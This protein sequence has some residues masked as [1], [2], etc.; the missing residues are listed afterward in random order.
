M[1]QDLKQEISSAKLLELFNECAA[2]KANAET[3]SF[4]MIYQMI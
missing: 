3:I 1:L 2:N 4:D